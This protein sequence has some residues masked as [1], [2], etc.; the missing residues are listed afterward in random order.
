MIL[1]LG[2]LIFGGIFKIAYAITGYNCTCETNETAFALKGIY[3]GQQYG[4]FEITDKDFAEAALG[5]SCEG[6]TV[7]C[8]EKE[9]EG[10]LS[11][12]IKGWQI[13][14]QDNDNCPNGYK[15]DIS[16]GG[17]GKCVEKNCSN[18][19]DC[20][21]NE[22]CSESMGCV[23]VVDKTDGKCACPDGKL[24]CASS[25]CPAGEDCVGGSCQK[26]TKQSQ[27]TACSSDSYCWELGEAACCIDGKCSGD[28]EACADKGCPNPSDTANCKCPPGY[29]AIGGVFGCAAD[30]PLSSNECQTDEDCTA[31]NNGKCSDLSGSEAEG[32]KHKDITKKC[33]Y[34]VP[35]E[36][37][38]PSS[39]DFSW[40]P[41]KG[42]LQTLIGAKIIPWIMGIVGLLCV[43]ILIIGGQMYMVSAGNEKN[44]EA[45]KKMIGAAV[46][47]LFFTL[48]AYIAVEMVIGMFTQ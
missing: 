47:G 44:M 19:A 18:D 16:A 35:P 6:G 48:V 13:K 36:L 22:I 1:V 29:K 21:N 10:T 11:D 27:E 4:D 26:P 15:C 17:S 9:Y 14:C 32:C 23:L 40:W 30:C 38:G 43:V 39:V 8:L 20:G 12:P 46:I 24:S 41:A 28:V 2:F 42:R 25:M 31:H 34:S 33:T 7:K 37:T 45:A 5:E 3:Q